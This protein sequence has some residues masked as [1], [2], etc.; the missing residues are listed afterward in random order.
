[1]TEG[2]DKRVY[3]SQGR[4]FATGYLVAAAITIFDG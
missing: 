4:I 1:M 2:K 3:D